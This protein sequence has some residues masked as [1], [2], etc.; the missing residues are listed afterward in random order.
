MVN[1]PDTVRFPRPR[2]AWSKAKGAALLVALHL[3]AGADSLLAEDWHRWRGPDGNGIAREPLPPN[4]DPE[5]VTWKAA[6]GTGFSS[7]SVAGG[8]LYTMG[9]SEGRETVWCLDAASGRVL[10][11]DAYPAALMPNLHDG[12]PG[13]TPVVDGDDVFALSKDGQ[14]HCYSG[15]SGSRRWKRNILADAGMSKPPEWGFS[16]SACVVGDILLVEAGV[17]IAIDKRSGEIAWRSQPFRPAYGTPLVFR[18]RDT[19]RI[20]VLKTDGLV[21]LD[22][23]NGGTLAFERWETSFDTNA[24]TPILHDTSLFISTGY[25]RGCA[26][27]QFDGQSLTKRYENQ[28][29][30]N[31][32]NNSVLIGGHLFG[33][34]GTAHRGRPTEFVCMEVESGRERWRVAPD[35]GL[36]CGSLIATADGTLIILT[37]RGELVTAAAN[38]EGFVPAVRAQVLGGRCWTSPVLS[39]GLVYCRNSRGDLVA[40]GKSAPTSAD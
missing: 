20:A 17:T 25:D 28:Q 34:D 30:S 32:M 4:F 37:E 22:A 21:I 33:F 35:A 1:A 9:H 19:Q 11:I 13:A 40:V 6:V 14:L 2:N 27:F 23:E 24:T 10:W 12:G 26:L 15:E 5:L 36:G 7:V 31:H 29:M 18:H 16:G 8:R 38:P 3:L 39:G